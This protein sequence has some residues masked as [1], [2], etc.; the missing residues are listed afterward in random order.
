M[1]DIEILIPLFGI[2]I[3]AGTVSYLAVTAVQV[4]RRRLLGEGLPAVEDILE[5]R[6]RLEELEEQGVVAAD[7]EL[8][9]R[10]AELEERL[11]FAE[12]LL[13]KGDLRALPP[14]ASDEVSIS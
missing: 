8:T 14:E 5:L 10:V 11:D 1:A 9:A 6:N 3:V 2:L 12:R 4:V 7:P 13:A